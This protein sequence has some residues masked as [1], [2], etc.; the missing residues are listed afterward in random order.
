MTHVLF[1]G[2]DSNDLVD[3]FG[4]F[5]EIAQ[6]W[7]LQAQGGHQVVHTNILIVCPLGEPGILVLQNL[8][9]PPIGDR[10]FIHE[11][12]GPRA[13]QNAAYPQQGVFCHNTL[14]A[15]RDAVAAFVRNQDLGALLDSL[16]KIPLQNPPFN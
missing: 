13:G 6:H 15:Y 10:F 4:K 3:P 5:W 2:L 11:S 14:P 8:I 7:P 12:A 9:H 16:G 1:L